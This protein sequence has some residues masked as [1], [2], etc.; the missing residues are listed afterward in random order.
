MSQASTR[1]QGREVRHLTG[2]LQPL[3]DPAPRPILN[4]ENLTLTANGH[5]FVTGSQQV[6]EITAKPKAPDV[7]K[8]SAEFELTDIPL[9]HVPPENLYRT[10][11]A[12]D[13]D[14]LYLACAQ[15][16][17]DAHPL[18]GGWFPPVTKMPHVGFGGTLLLLS[19]LL[20]DVRSCVMRADLRRR[21]LEFG[22]PIYLTGKCFANGLAVDGNGFLYVANSLPFADAGIHRLRTGEWQQPAEGTSTLWY[23]TDRWSVP[24]GIKLKDK[25]LCFTRIKLPLS[26]TL[27]EIDLGDPP[28]LINDSLCSELGVFFDDFDTVDEGFVVAAFVDAKNVSGA[29]RFYDR[30]GTHR[31]T[32]SDPQIKHPS[33][34]IQI[35]RAPD[36]GEAGDLL[37]TE[38]DSHTVWRLRLSNQPW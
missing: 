18:L 15:I 10:G 34:V 13:G 5:L 28:N 14:Y 6:C 9:A 37:V 35:R 16:N 21:P 25:S 11:I 26:S 22:E 19:E 3:L 23:P 1:H 7:P 29:L 36:F 32:F 33:A 20:C 27:T 17:Q 12:A 8:P 38:K 30:D 2:S 4:A 24:N 31:A